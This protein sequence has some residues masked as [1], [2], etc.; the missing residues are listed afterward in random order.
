[1]SS[2]DN[3]KKE[4]KR[5]LR[6]LRAGDPRT[7]LRSVQLSLAREHGFDD[8]NAMSHALR[9]AA[10]GDALTPLESDV[11]AAIARQDRDALRRIASEHPAFLS[12]HQAWVRLIAH[13]VRR[14]DA[15]VLGH[16]L[17]IDRHAHGGLTSV[18]A[19]I[20]AGARWTALHE[21]ARIGHVDVVRVLLQRGADPRARDHGCAT[22]AAVARQAGRS[23]AADVILE[24]NRTDMFD[25]IDADRADLVERIAE[26][27]PAALERPFGMYATC[28]GGPAA[29]TTPL[30]WAAA[31]GR[32]HARRAL[33]ERMAGTRTADDI[34]RAER[35]VTFLQSACW[36][37][38]VHGKG[39]HRMHDRAAG[40]LLAH[41]PW[42][43]RHSLYTAI[44]C[45]EIDEV[46]R[47]VAEHPEKAR[48]P[49]GP[50][51]WTP[52]L[53]LAYT[54]FTHAATH[55]HAVAIARLLLDAGADPNAYYMAGDARYSV[56][57]GVAG[58]GEQDSPR[59]PWAEAMY[60]LLLD[61]GAGPYDIQVLYDTH[62][63]T[64]MLWW[65]QL[66]YDYSV[67]H[68]MKA[69]W[70]DPAWSMLDMG[71]Y[72][73][74]AYFVIDRAMR[75]NNVALVDWALAHGADPNAM[76]TSHPKF[77]PA[78]SL[79]DAA[80]ILGRTEIAA[81]LA[82]HGATSNERAVDP[83]ERLSMAAL[84][85]DR[86]EAESLLSAH[87]QLKTSMRALF[88]AASQ[89]RVDALELLESLG[90]S[91][92]A[93]DTSNTRAL[94]NA[95]GHG[96]LKA[97][98]FLID[99]GVDVDPVETNYGAAPVGWASHGD[100]VAAIDLLSRYSREI[101]TLCFRG[102]VNRVRAIVHDDPALARQTDG[103]GI[104]PLWWLPDD[105]EAALE[106]VQILIAAGA[107]PAARSKDGKT[108]ADWARRRGMFAIAARL[109]SG[110][111]A[112]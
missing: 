24:S 44:V 87:P 85:L 7:T 69:D 12:D 17:D 16:L 59:Q 4:A 68:G 40:R 23:E 92:D 37:H 33:V 2:L 107:D 102:Y 77:R 108:A 100:H 110:R 21:A 31:Q 36:D 46:R 38:H 106:M 64:D 89:D 74:G 53:Y 66:T 51:S 88:D 49:G 67:A 1:V 9:A 43:A 6:T 57:T 35:A 73:P 13:A 42:M 52:L 22:P 54:R 99:K 32:E 14:R 111:Q 50:R 48:Q 82:R 81:L 56:L 65:L 27:D 5:R 103:D 34:A 79:Y 20:A 80:V 70:D 19:E 29:S 61:R 45:G 41:D 15:A 91:L 8:W 101:W 18:N 98:Q 3:L 97:I 58:E 26:R 83:E 96:A 10:R 39:D 25:A 71:G 112:E 90:F 78:R 84:R 60:A 55:A 76:T 95:G 86:R 93:A 105:E 109:E 104:T 72:G 30:D 63:S 75:K 28:A 11:M 94:H 62:F 47:I